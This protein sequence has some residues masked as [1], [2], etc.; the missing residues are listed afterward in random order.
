MCLNKRKG[1][2]LNL[3]S[4][5]LFIADIPN[6]P[7][8]RPF[9]G[10][11]ES[12]FLPS[13]LGSKLCR[14]YCNNSPAHS[15]WAGDSTLGSKRQGDPPINA[16]GQQKSRNGHDAKLRPIRLTEKLSAKSG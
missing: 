16:E 12:I 6:N 5:Y 13:G 11:R 8:S 9:A 4:L 2:K 7:G 14:G 1:L 3:Q 15:N 10:H